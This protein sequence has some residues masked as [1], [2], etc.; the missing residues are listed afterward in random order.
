[1]K[2]KESL[3]YIEYNVVGH[4]NLN[5]KGC[6]HF[7][8]IQKKEFADLAT[9]EKDISML[10]KLFSEIRRINLLGGEPL[11]HPELASFI[12]T[13]RTY[14]PDAELY[15]TTNGLLIPQIN[16]ELIQT[17]KK[18]KVS[19]HITIYQPI[20]QVKEKILKFLQD[21]QI[22]Y[23]L[24]ESKEKFRKKM[25]LEG[26]QNPKHSYRNCRAKQCFCFHNGLI[27]NCPMNLYIDRF[28]EYFHTDIKGNVISFYDTT[29]TAKE[30]KRKLL[31]PNSLCQYCSP[32]P[33]F[34]EWES[35]NGKEICQSDWTIQKGEKHDKK[36]LI[37]EI[38]IANL[39]EKIKSIPGLYGVIKRIKNRKST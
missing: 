9:F 2:K 3:D 26:N 16:A 8:N 14:Y 11:L 22:A 29:L 37:E 20:L 28:N 39:K 38:M 15:I 24:I 7:S 33:V 10:K 19:F 23:T 17:M 5:C 21:H 35:T 4:C 1:M 12:Q 32:Y 30:I 34:F 36:R 27:A 13:T 25:K 18:C 31:K 6:S